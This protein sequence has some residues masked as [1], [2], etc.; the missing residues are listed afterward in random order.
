MLD[1]PRGSL[2]S[3]NG[4]F[5]IKPPNNIEMQL[6]IRLDAEVLSRRVDTSDTRNL[7]VIYKNKVVHVKGGR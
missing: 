5:P 3:T 1:N 2:I 6:L 7:M 4:D